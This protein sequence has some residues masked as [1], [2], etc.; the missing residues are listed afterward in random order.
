MTCAQPLVNPA[1]TYA[2]RRAA[3]TH[4]SL[5][6]GIYTLLDLE[7]VLAEH[8]HSP[9]PRLSRTSI[10]LSF[11]AN[12]RLRA[13]ISASFTRLEKSE[14]MSASEDILAPVPVPLELSLVDVPVPPAV[15]VVEDEDTAATAAG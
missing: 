13:V 14:S 12:L 15:N 4:D 11:L 6:V 8:T 7:P 9:G 10:H 3:P 5:Q 1:H 2:W